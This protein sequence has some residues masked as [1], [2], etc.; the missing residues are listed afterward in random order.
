MKRILSLF[1][2][3]T[4]IVGILAGCAVN[5]TSTDV[6][7]KTLADFET[8]KIGII[9]G[10]SHEETVKNYFPNAE[11]VYFNSLADMLMAVE[12]EKIDCYIEDTPFVTALIWEGV[13]FKCLDETVSCVENGF[14]FPEGENTHIR[15][16]INSF[17]SEA[18]ADGTIEQLK[19]KWMGA[20]EPEE[21]PDYRALEGENGTIHLSICLDSKPYIYQREN[22]YT[23]FEI[24]LLTLFG[25]K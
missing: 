5:D 20:T 13:N 17:L 9:T 21:H 12:Q 14:I 4:I 11:R 19:K 24:E 8:A 22:N 23:G 2:L 16:Q 15:K 18:K 6:E 25:R 7:K 10:S 3:I 1:L